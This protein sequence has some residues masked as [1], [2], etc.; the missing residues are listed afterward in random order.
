MRQGPEPKRD[1]PLNKDVV[2]I[3]RADD[4]DIVI[5]DKEAA[6]P[7]IQIEDETST[8]IPGKK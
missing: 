4:N 5:E 2:M 1:N 7:P 3:G 8:V 6:H